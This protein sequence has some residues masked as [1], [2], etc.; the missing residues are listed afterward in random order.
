MYK[1]YT[2]GENL[3]FNA[4]NS[5]ASTGRRWKGNEYIQ[6]EKNTF[7]ISYELIEISNIEKR[8]ERWVKNY[9]QAY[10]HLSIGWRPE[11]LYA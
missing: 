10:E 11:N 2:L 7:K 9:Y 8:I 6:A 5:P 4:K 1:A 3:T